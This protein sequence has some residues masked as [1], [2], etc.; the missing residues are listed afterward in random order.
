MCFVPV[1]YSREK[2]EISDQI[3]EHLEEK[4]LEDEMKEQEKRQIRKK[5]EKMNLEDLKVQTQAL[6]M[7]SL[8]SHLHAQGAVPPHVW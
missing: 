8:K 5:L 2:Q 7:R 1:L 6:E 3:Q 4:Q